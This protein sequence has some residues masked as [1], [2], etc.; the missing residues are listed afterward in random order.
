ML[1]SL[2][3]ALIL[4]TLSSCRL[5]TSSDDDTPAQDPRLIQPLQPPRNFTGA[6]IGRITRLCDASKELRLRLDGFFDRDLQYTFDLQ[7]KRCIDTTLAPAGNGRGI[8]RR[9]VSGTP[10][11]ESVGTSNLI[12]DFFLDTHPYLA[13]LCQDLRTNLSLTN[14][15]TL[16]S[17]QLIYEVFES[18]RMDAIQITR[19]RPLASGELA[20]ALIDTYKVYTEAVTRNQD[21]LGEVFERSQT[22]P[23]P[24]STQSQ[25]R[26][27]RL[28]QV[29][30]P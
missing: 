20:V 5:F 22:L 23:C 18:E 14:Q 13:G 8:F 30:Q 1:K 19:Y 6:E 29:Q 10:F 25:T 16:G 3:I 17:D 9:P 12:E 15:R 2:W 28:V 27:Q 11:L 7:R 4:L 26:F 21:I 24:I